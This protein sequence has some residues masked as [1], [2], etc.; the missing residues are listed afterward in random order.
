MIWPA[1][2]RE[3]QK[4]HALKHVLCL[5]YAVTSCC[6]EWRTAVQAGGN[7]GLWPMRLA[8]SFEKVIT[9]EPEPVSRACLVENVK[10]L[11]NVTVLPFVLGSERRSCG[12]ERRSLGSHVV[13]E[14]G[15]IEM[16]RLDDLDLA[17]VDLIQLDIEGYEIHALR[18]GVE[19]I[20]KWKPVIQVEILN[21]L[22]LSPIFAFML[23]ESYRLRK[24]LGRDFVFM[25]E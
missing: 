10:R 20:R 15:A 23:A 19:T 2:T 4:A 17:D 6:R 14:D 1:D 18:G 25:P 22:A 13:T 9:F 3:S 7:V 16:I 21:R 5:E 24:D 11:K 8:K 12:I